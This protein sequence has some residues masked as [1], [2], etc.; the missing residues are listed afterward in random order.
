M[1]RLPRIDRAI[2]AGIPMT[3][4]LQQKIAGDIISAHYVMLQNWQVQKDYLNPP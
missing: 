2:G 4:S 1:V 3:P